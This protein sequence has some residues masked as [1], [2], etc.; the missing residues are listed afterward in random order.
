M[1]ENFQSSLETTS[2]LNEAG[3]K[4]VLSRA[5]TEIQAKFLKRNGADLGH[6]PRK[7]DG[8]TAGGALQRGQYLRLH[9]A[10]P[11]NTRSMRSR[12]RAA[13]EG[14]TIRD[15][16]VRAKYNLNILGGQAGR[17]A[18]PP[19]RRG[20]SVQHQRAADRDVPQRG[21]RKDPL[22]K[23][24]RPRR[25]RRGRLFCTR[26]RREPPPPPA[27]FDSGSVTRHQLST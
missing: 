3:A 11:P 1:G 12:H 17:D 4:Y 25:E 24:K 8:G 2:L 15:K 16:N 22:T 10:H 9:P 19:A 21:H 14:K 18:H 5:S 20:P 27:F 6:L 26:K 7:A 13:W 23:R